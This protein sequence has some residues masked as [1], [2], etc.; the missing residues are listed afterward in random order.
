MDD[1]K[2]TNIFLGP[3][4]GAVSCRWVWPLRFGDLFFPNFTVLFDRWQNGEV[5]R[6]NTKDVLFEGGLPKL[7]GNCRDSP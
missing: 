6:T 4:R 5:M 7:C 2:R 3:A 1:W